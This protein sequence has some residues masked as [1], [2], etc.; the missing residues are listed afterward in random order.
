MVE[1]TFCIEKSLKDIK[2]LRQF[3]I[4]LKTQQTKG[5]EII[6]LKGNF[7]KIFYIKEI[8]CK[9]SYKKEFF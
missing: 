2:H 3:S 4:I 7:L 1:K 8:F 6:F 9:I 5:R